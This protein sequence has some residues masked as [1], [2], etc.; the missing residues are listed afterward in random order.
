M[1]VNVLSEPTSYNHLEIDDFLQNSFQKTDLDRL[2]L[3]NVQKRIS[4]I[5]AVEDYQKLMVLGKPGAGKSTFC[6]TL[7]LKVITEIY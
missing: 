2:G 3:A 4:G 1:D 6:S 5:K 7:S